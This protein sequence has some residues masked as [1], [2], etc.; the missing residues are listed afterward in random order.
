MNSLGN[1]DS[2]GEDQRLGSV[3]SLVA[4]PN[5]CQRGDVSVQSR[6]EEVAVSRFLILPDAVTG[7]IA[8]RQIE[9]RSSD[10]R[11]CGKLEQ[12]DRA[13]QI[14]RMNCTARQ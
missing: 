8:H 9:M 3:H 14:F 2:V 6:S 1:E 13:A 7:L 12:L 11:L 4:A 5:F 10:I